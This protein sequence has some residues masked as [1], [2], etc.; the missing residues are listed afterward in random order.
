MIMHAK[1]A[2]NHDIATINQQD[3]TAILCE[4]KLT[5]TAPEVEWWADFVLLSGLNVSLK[6]LK[7]APIVMQ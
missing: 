3:V 5:L 4:K 1:K 6:W 2:V 7:P